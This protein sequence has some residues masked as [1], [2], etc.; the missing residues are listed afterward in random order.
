MEAKVTLSCSLITGKLVIEPTVPVKVNFTASMC[1][2]DHDE[3]FIVI[4]SF[5]SKRLDVNKPTIKFNI[6]KSNIPFKWIFFLG[7]KDKEDDDE[8]NSFILRNFT[9]KI[10]NIKVCRISIHTFN[11]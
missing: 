3:K 10:I 5:D 9:M 1:Q 8:T 7:G 4:G 11:S 6:N 2:S